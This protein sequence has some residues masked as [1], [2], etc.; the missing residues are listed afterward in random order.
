MLLTASPHFCALAVTGALAFFAADLQGFDETLS[1][2]DAPV[3]FAAPVR[4]MAG[5]RVWALEAK[6]SAPVLVDR[7]GDGDLDP[8]L[9]LASG[10]ARGSAPVREV[11]RAYAFTDFSVLTNSSISFSTFAAS[12]S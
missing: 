1:A 2:G 5:D 6:M 8:L 3:Q 12:L 4:L 10:P 9:G 7:D 11:T